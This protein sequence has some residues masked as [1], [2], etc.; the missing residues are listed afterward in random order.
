MGNRMISRQSASILA[1]AGLPGF[2]APDKDSYVNI[3]I[4]WS[5]KKE[6]LA[7]MRKQLRQRLKTSP[8]CDSARFTSDLEQI[9][10]E[11]WKTWCT[12]QSKPR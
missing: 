1:S 5:G 3:A 9:Y 7:Q 2:I 4:D 12:Q 6:Q 11:A 8:V 10:R